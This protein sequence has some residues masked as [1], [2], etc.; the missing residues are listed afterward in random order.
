VVAGRQLL[1]D[2]PADATAA[3]GNDRYRFGHSINDKGAAASAGRN[4][5]I[6]RILERESQSRL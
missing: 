2:G 1:D 5:Q 3:S 6:E 4:L